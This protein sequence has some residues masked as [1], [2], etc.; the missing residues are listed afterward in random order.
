VYKWVRDTKKAIELYPQL[1]TNVSETVN[2]FK[3]SNGWLPNFGKRRNLVL[4]RIT[5]KGREAP[6]NARLSK[7]DK[8]GQLYTK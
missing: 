7:D 5:T 1:Y 3:A 2:E 4:R 8:L 6:K